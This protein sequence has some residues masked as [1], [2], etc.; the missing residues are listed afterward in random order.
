MIADEKS[1]PGKAAGGP[2]WARLDELDDQGLPLWKAALIAAAIE[3]LVPFLV[4]GVD[5]SF[6]GLTEPPPTPVMNV[7]LEPPPEPPPPPPPEKRKPVPEKKVEQ[8]AVEQ[9]PADPS[10]K[11]Q[12]PKPEPKKP[13]PKPKKQEPPPPE[14]E[15]N[16]K[17]EEPEAPPL[18]SVFRDVKPVRKVQPKYPPEAEAQHV[19]GRVRVRLSVDLDGN[20]TDVETL[21]SE[22]PGV[23]DAAVQ[24]AVR[25][26]KFKRDGT[27]YKADQE[28]VFKIDP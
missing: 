12:L 5:W 1:D 8:V 2:L 7:R 17:P 11:I 15:P 4:F 14:P 19:E 18:P 10:A 28:I 13:K 9:P 24:E 23:F 16:P 27:T 21:Q 25:Q 26:Y 20:V 3:L 22:P 6:L